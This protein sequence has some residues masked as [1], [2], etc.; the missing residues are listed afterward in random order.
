MYQ[1][2]IPGF[3]VDDYQVLTSDYTRYLTLLPLL[4][5]LPHPLLTISTLHTAHSVLGKVSLQDRAV[6][7]ITL[8]LAAAHN[9]GCLP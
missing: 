2:I 9:R 7:A 5:R 6:L 8:V 4:V 3:T 1:T